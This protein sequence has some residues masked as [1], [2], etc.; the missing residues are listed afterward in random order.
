M[1]KLTIGSWP[2]ILL[3]AA[4]IFVV[5]S[6]A[7]WFFYNHYDVF[8]DP[9]TSALVASAVAFYDKYL[10]PLISHDPD[11]EYWRSQYETQRSRREA[12][13][14]EYRNYQRTMGA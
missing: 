10:R 6:F 8:R 9:K 12:I 11:V 13:E 1:I 4:I 7:L 3:R 5:S 2:S 14:L